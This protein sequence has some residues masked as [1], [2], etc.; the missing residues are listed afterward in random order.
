MTYL[1]GTVCAYANMSKALV[2]RRFSERFEN[3]ASRY[4][5]SYTVH[6]S[7]TG[8]NIKSDGIT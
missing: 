3:T 6:F 2:F 5:R 1:K 7:E 8:R 4:V